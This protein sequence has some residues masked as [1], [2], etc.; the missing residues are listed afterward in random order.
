MLPSLSGDCLSNAMPSL[1]II[2]AFSL[3][4]CFLHFMIKPLLTVLLPWCWASG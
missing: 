2:M 4:A 3:N 1:P